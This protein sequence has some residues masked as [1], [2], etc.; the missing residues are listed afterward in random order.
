MMKLALL[1]DYHRVATRMADWGRLAGRVE[2]ASFDAKIADA[3]EL[4]RRLALDAIL[5][6]RERT[7]FPR[8]VLERLPNLRL[9][10]TTGLWNAAIDVDAAMELGVQ[11]CGTRDD[12]HLTAELTL[13]LMLALARETSH[14]E[15]AMR[16]GRWHVRLGH[17]VRGKTLGI[18]GLVNLGRQVAGFGRRVGMETIAWSQNLT[19]AAAAEAGCRLVERTKLFATSDYLTIH[20]RLSDR[21]RGLVGA[22]ELGLMKPSAYLIHTS[23]GP[24]V[25][26]AA[27]CR[28]LAR[29]ADCRGGSRRL[30]ARAAPH[31]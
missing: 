2:V 17:S 8:P 15:R 23:R 18:L 25:D 9:L 22:A 4:I 12:G 21:T 1:D 31:G 7:A 29:A 26:E 10:I 30:L 16:E 11:V 13:G 14:E 19:A 28:A 3:D 6:M 27:L 5:A 24:I 20:V